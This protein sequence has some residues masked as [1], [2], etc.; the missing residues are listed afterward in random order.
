MEPQLMRELRAADGRVIRRWTPQPSHR[1]FQEQTTAT[2][3]T[4]LSAV[5]DSGTATATRVAGM[6]VAG[7]T[8][9]AQKF[10]PRTRSYGTGMYIGSFAGFAPAEDPRLVGVVV[11]DEPR[12]NRYYGG[13]VA[14]PVF[15]EIVLDLLRSPSGILRAAPNAVAMRPPAVPA[16]IAPDLRLLPP[17]E[18]ERRLRDAGLRGDLV[19]DGPR[20]LSQTPAAGQP[21]ERGTVV[22][23]FLDAPVDSSG[24]A[25]PDLVGLSAREALA[26]LSSRSVRAIVRGSGIVVRMDPPA[27]TPLP[28]QGAC[29]IDCELAPL[30]DGTRSASGGVASALG[31]QR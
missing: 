6:H 23:A 17:R 29:R 7:K 2:L 13:Q 24:P 12:G 30:S 1:V 10:D 4:M 11:I 16:V 26:K 31:R 18:A 21:L 25:L 20:V 14:A 5:V 9:T 28:I 27:G 19:G 22:V 3:S 8:G 15:R